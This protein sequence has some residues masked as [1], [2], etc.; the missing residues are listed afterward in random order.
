VLKSRGRTYDES[1]EK[2]GFGGMA[3]SH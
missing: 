2:E 3:S 1:R